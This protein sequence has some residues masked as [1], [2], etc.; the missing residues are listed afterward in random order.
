MAICDSLSVTVAPSEVRLL[1]ALELLD[2]AEGGDARY[3]SPCTLGPDHV[4][5]LVNY[6]KAGN[7]ALAACQAQAA[8]RIRGL[9]DALRAAVEVIKN[10]H[11]MDGSD[12]VWD[13]YYRNAPEMRAIRDILGVR[14]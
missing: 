12:D 7:D 3:A 1:E 6:I 2:L 9:E 11:N 10:W 4:Q 5:A 14:P 8:G 13:I